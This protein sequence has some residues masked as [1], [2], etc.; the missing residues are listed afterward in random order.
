MTVYYKPFR[1][2]KAVA[3]GAIIPKR[4]TAQSAGYDLHAREAVTILPKETKLV[5]TGITAKMQHDE[6]LQ[7]RSRSGL[8][9]KKGVFVLNSTGT[10]DADYYPNEIGVILYNISDEPFT[11]EVGDRIAQAVFAKYL[12]V[13]GDDAEGE[14]AGGFGHTGV[15]L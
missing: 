13:T 8:A 4:A 6:E 10:V 3:E 9:L 2:F 14:R 15:K 7:I 12:T 1:E 5:K 11:V